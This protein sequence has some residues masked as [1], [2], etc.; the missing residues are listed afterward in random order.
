MEHKNIGLYFYRGYYLNYFG[1][2]GLL[3]LG[4]KKQ[5]EVAA[6]NNK[7]FTKFDDISHNKYLKVNRINL[8][9]SITLKTTYPGLYTGSGYTFGAG[10]QGEFQLGFLF[11]HTTGLPYLPGSSVK[12][13]IRSVFPNYD[14]ANK[15]TDY[16]EERVDFIWT[17]YFKKMPANCFTKN[18]NVDSDKK[19]VVVAEIELE[20]FDGRN[21]TLEKDNQSKKKEV[22]EEYLSIYQ[23]D[24]FYDVFISATVKQGK[25][26]DK[27]LGTDYITPH[28]S[29]TKN[30]TPL[31]F[32]KIL[33]GVTVNFQFQLHDGY[34]LTAEGKKHLFRQILL[35]FGIGA[36]T[37]VGYGQFTQ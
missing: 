10:L 28:R 12:G 23:R 18:F 5:Q 15:S 7:K 8:V 13:A 24:I 2:N 34:Y 25:T 21:I 1:E 22:T 32:L 14:M 33:P 37:N 4:E 20:I 26:K 31:P 17:E 29:A 6:E 35:D 27:F 36:K 16:K 3:S 30:P 9:Q 19:D 11:D